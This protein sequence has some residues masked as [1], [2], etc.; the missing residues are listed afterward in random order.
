MINNS[1]LTHVSKHF[2]YK[3]YVYLL[4]LQTD[5]ILLKRNTLEELS[6]GYRV[7]VTRGQHC[8]L[9]VLDQRNLMP[10]TNTV[11]CFYRSKVRSKCP[12]LKQYA[13]GEVD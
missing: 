1:V 7:R 4:H 10:N 2:T 5:D 3:V 9:K 12:D 11:L 13:S 8:H 6:L